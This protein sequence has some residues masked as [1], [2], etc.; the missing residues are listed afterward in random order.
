VLR[1]GRHGEAAVG[2]VVVV[3]VLAGYHI[4]AAPSGGDLLDESACGHGGGVRLLGCCSDYAETSLGFC[5]NTLLLEYGNK[6]REVIGWSSL[7]AHEILCRK[8]ARDARL[9][10]Q[11]R[12]PG[13]S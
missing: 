12:S 10:L 9:A 2:C 1:R 4:W 8:E 11:A 6:E 7:G 3:E 5:A 13:R